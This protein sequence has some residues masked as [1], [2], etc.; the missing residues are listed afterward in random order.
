M[1][2]LTRHREVEQSQRQEPRLDVTN[3]VFRIGDKYARVPLVQDDGPDEALVGLDVGDATGDL[4]QESDGGRNHGL[5][6]I[7]QTPFIVC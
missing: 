4:G 3:D 7:L 6:L 2:T 1:G 5:N